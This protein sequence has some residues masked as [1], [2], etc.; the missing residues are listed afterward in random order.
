VLIALVVSVALNLFVGGIVVGR[1]VAVGGL[2]GMAV[3]LLADP[4]E[5]PVRQML[6]RIARNLEP[7]ERARLRAAVADRRE[8]LEAA[9][10]GIAEARRTV[11]ELVAAPEFDRAAVDTAL[12]E[13]RQRTTAFQAIMQMA[14]VDAVAE[15][16]EES[17][18]RLV[19]GLSGNRW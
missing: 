5:R 13:L 3:S 7:A 14:V 10:H 1:Q 16:P 19:D 18:R 12:A 11:G 9:G 17:R 2:G 4:G 8:E 6:M 15:L